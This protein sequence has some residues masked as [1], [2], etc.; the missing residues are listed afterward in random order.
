VTFKSANNL[1]IFHNQE[2]FI[3]SA[4]LTEKRFF[5]KQALITKTK[6]VQIKAG[7]PAIKP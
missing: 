3:K 2:L 1:L 5:D 7:K 4:Y 6:Y